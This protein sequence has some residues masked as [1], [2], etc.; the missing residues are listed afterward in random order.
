MDFIL[1]VDVA[2][3]RTIDFP[4]LA[5]AKTSRFSLI[6]GKNAFSVNRF[7]YETMRF[8]VIGDLIFPEAVSASNDGKAEFLN[9]HRRQNTIHTLKGFFYLLAFD[10]ANRTIEIH[11]SFLNILPLFL[12]ETPGRV[13][14]SSS[15]QAVSQQPEFQA[16]RNELFMV[17]KVLFNY[18]FLN[19]TPYKNIALVPSCH[20]LSLSTDGLVKKQ[21]LQLEAMLVAAPRPW[22]EHLDELSDVFVAEMQVYIPREPFALTLTGGFDGR[23]VLS[24]ARKA[25]A[26]FETFSYGLATDLDVLVP[27]MLCRSLGLIHRPFLL[28]EKYAADHFWENG[29]ELVAATEGAANISRAHYVLTASEMAKQYRYFLTGNFGS[30]LIRSWK[31]PGVMGS[32]VL[33]ALFSSASKQVFS[34]FVK[35]YPF[36]RLLRPELLQ[37]NLE[38]VIDTAWDYRES[39]PADFSVNQRFYLYVFGE[40]FRKYFGP[41]IVLQSRY[42]VNRSPFLDFKVMQTLLTTSLAGAYSDFREENPFRRFHGQVLYAHILRKTCP[43]LLD[44]DLDRGYKP[45]DFLSPFGK[46]KIVLGYMKRRKSRPKDIITPSYSTV[47]YG[48]NLNKIEAVVANSGTLNREYFKNLLAAGGWKTM[49]A[50]FANALSM[51]LFFQRDF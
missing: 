4:E 18:S 6:A 21:S 19:H 10:A 5:E 48:M 38:E 47:C 46:I 35:N 2:E 29:L 50:E 23:T 22:K 27:Q 51:E 7:S 39:L 34:E 30:E 28:D 25:K 8:I 17:E 49:Q 3:L 13:T 20:H 45:A 42:L 32:P 37:N 31:N 36:L 24:L 1:T 9:R 26:V 41:E 44:L 16:E 40:V 43:E 15:L 12:R 14:V 11:S 33:F